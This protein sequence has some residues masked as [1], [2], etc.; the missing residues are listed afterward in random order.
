M[1]K[2]ASQRWYDT[3]PTVSLAVSF[4]RSL[5]PERRAE[6]AKKIIEHAR[7]LGIS[8]NEVKIVFKRRWYDENEELSTAMEYLHQASSRDRKLIALDIIDFLTQ[9]K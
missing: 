9:I 5:S 8:I 3:D 2:S 1:N 6:I 7:T 4:I